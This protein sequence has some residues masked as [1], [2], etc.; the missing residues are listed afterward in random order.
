MSDGIILQNPSQLSIDSERLLRASQ[1]VLDCH[2]NFEAS[3]LSIVLSDSKTI[4]ALNRQFAAVDSPTDVLSF[5]AG[6][7]P[8]D[9]DEPAGYLGDIIIAHDYAAAQAC[10]S[11]TAFCDLLCLLIIHG[12][13]H[14]LGYDHDRRAAR[15]KMWAAQDRCLRQLNIDPAIV[16]QYQDIA[17][18]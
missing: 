11:K 8:L 5:R 10:A 9:I 16:D 12:T 18:G 13:L 1:T 7:L 14:L 3:S 6:A 2:A 15:E 17:H 4:R